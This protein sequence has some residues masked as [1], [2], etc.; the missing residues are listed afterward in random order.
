MEA[1]KICHKL[2]LAVMLYDTTT[3]LHVAERNCKFFFDEKPIQPLPRGGGSYIFLNLAQE[4]KK[5]R[6]EVK[7]YEVAEVTV[8]YES[9]NPQMPILDMFLIPSENNPYGEQMIALTGQLPGIESIDAV[10]LS[11]SYC[12]S[13]EYN[14]RERVMKI[15]K[16]NGLAMENVHYGLLNKNMQE[17]RYEYF[18]IEKV[19]PPSSIK[20]QEPLKEPF[21]SNSPIA[22]IIFGQVRPD[23]TYL[24][25][26]RDQAT[27][28]K[29]IVRYV[30]GGESR[31]QSVD[32][33]NLKDVK[34]V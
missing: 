2:S 24:L 5:M 13:G 30:V 29:G 7:G 11:Q 14:E 28:L 34:L 18:R 27:V 4:N 6:V 21:S 32:F 10:L 26:V 20:L 19:I 25:R 15:L 23:G 22:R 33:H 12:S 9:L 17:G 3:G 1:A 31:F 16:K 8:D